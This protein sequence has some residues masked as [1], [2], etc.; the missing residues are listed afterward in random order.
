M[1]HRQGRYKPARGG[2][3]SGQP[4]LKA[5]K[6]CQR[7]GRSKSKD[8]AHRARN[9]ESNSK[10]SKV[11]RPMPQRQIIVILSQQSSSIKKTKLRIDSRGFHH[12]VPKA[13]GGKRNLK[14]GLNL[15]RSTHDYWHKLFGNATP[16]EILAILE[17]NIRDRDLGD[18]QHLITNTCFW[19]RL[20]GGKSLEMV[21]KI[22]ERIV[23]MK[24]KNMTLGRNEVQNLSSRPWP[25][26]SKEH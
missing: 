11:W 24:Q 10:K 4:P 19:N 20:F 1:I 18:T 17:V 7:T 3:P 9:I 21:Q 23:R 5:R 8:D 15:W 22:I 2:L 12:L 14:N 13:R 16:G 6:K 25:R 26:W